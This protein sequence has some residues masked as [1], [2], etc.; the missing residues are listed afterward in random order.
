MRE[1]NDELNAWVNVALD[2][3][4]VESARVMRW[5]KLSRQRIFG[6]VDLSLAYG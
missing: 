1:V 3:V 4:F 5:S 6:I 2:F